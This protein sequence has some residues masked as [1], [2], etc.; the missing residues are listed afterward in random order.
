[1]GIITGI[2]YTTILIIMYTISCIYHA[3]SY[4]IKGKEILRNID[5]SN[6][7]LT[8][9]G[10]YTPIALCLIKGSLGWIIFTIVWCITAIAITF[11]SINV[12]KYQKICLLCN[13]IVGWAGLLIIKQLIQS[14][15][16]EGLILLIGGGIIY[17]IGAILYVLGKKHR[18]IHSLFHF[19]ILVASILH[20]LFIY[21]YVV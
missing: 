15:P 9:A 16:I 14:C 13:L 11:N 20:Y 4:R 2:I 12:E 17:T 8:V 21:F 19:L 18:Y 5:H 3:L 7:L 1:M 6:V 10:T